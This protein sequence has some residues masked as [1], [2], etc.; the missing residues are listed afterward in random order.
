VTKRDRDVLIFIENYIAER[1]YPP[2][3]KEIGDACGMR[4]KSSV[5]SHIQR[6]LKEGYLE[7][8]NKGKTRAYRIALK[9]H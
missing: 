4:S 8:D 1:K 5:H 6:L 3:Y 7:T 9:E 2:S